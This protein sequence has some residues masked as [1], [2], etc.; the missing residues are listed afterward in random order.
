M[1]D[2]K[3]SRPEVKSPVRVGKAPLSIERAREAK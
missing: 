2:G 1:I 3:P